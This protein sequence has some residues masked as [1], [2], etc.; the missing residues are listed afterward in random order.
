[1]AKMLGFAEE[2]IPM[3]ES[4]MHGRKLAGPPCMHGACGSIPSVVAAAIISP[5]FP[6]CLIGNPAASGR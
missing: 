4:D 3:N 5:S 6:R 2:A 1:M